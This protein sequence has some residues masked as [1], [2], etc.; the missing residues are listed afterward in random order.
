MPERRLKGLDT[1]YLTIFED[2]EIIDSDI[3]KF[4]DKYEIFKSSN[5]FHMLNLA[6]YRC[7]KM[8]RKAATKQESE[9]QS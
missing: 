1:R 6:S 9:L 3:H 7:L 2:F 5:S 4:L 8:L